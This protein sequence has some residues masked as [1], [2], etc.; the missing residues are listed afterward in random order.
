MKNSKL[1][2][3]RVRRVSV[4]LR[5]LGYEILQGQLIEDTY[6][7]GFESDDGF[8]GGI[9][10]DRE[11]KFL[12]FAYT[13]SFSANLADYVQGKLEDMLQ[14][15]YEY[16]CYSN[17]QSGPRE[18]SFSIF[19]KIYYAGLN[20]YSLKE[21]VRDYREAVESLAEIVDLKQELGRGT[22]GGNAQ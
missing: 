2:K 3:E 22:T 20:Y 16:G 5:E 19:S 11:C 15:C 17:L 21:T 6:S 4:L 8:Q 14:V 18:I 10:I 12:E 9:F 7:A 1:I 13:F